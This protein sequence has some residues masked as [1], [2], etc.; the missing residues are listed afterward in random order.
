MHSVL[1]NA[2]LITDPMMKT[3]SAVSGFSDAKA[4]K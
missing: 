2:F 3:E 4:S 1:S